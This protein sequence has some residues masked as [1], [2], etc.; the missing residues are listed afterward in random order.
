MIGPALVETGLTPAEC[1][2]RARALR[3]EGRRLLAEQERIAHELR[4][5][6]WPQASAYEAI[7]L[8]MRKGGNR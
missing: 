6:V 1:E 5:R 4:N 3:E 8:V 2:A 7:A